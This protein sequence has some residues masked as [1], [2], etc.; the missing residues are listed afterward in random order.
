ML[1]LTIF[2]LVSLEV[3]NMPVII[4]NEYNSSNRTTLDFKNKV[5]KAAQEFLW[6]F[7]ANNEVR[8]VD[9]SGDGKYIIAGSHDGRIYVFNSN[10]NNTLWT[11]NTGSELR[12]VAMSYNGSYMVG[13]CANGYIYCF[14]ISSNQSLWNY[15][16]GQEI[17]TVDISATGEF[18]AAGGRSNIVYYFNNT[19]AD[20]K[21]PLWSFNTGNDI[22]A[23][24]L[25]ANGSYI[26]AGNGAGWLYFFNNSIT[27]PKAYE[28]ADRTPGM[29]TPWEI[30]ISDDGFYIA[31][32]DYAGTSN[33]VSFYNRTSDIPMWNYSIGAWL[34]GIAISGDGKYVVAGARTNRVYLFDGMNTVNPYLWEDFL[35][36][37]CW[38]VDISKNGEYIIAGT[39]D[40]GSNPQIYL[41][42]KA[43]N[44]PILQHAAPGGLGI[45]SVAAS[46][47]GEYFAAG[48]YSDKIITFYQNIPSAPPGPINLTHTASNPDDDGVFN[49]VWNESIG[50]ETYAIYNCTQFIT[51][52]NS[53][54]KEMTSGLINND[55]FEISG[56]DNGTY[57][58]VV[59]ARNID[60]NATSNCVE[61]NVQ[62]SPSTNGGPN[63]NGNGF[64]IIEFLTSPLGIVM[65]GSLIA[66]VSVIIIIIKKKGSD[67]LRNE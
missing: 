14:H 41:Y 40:S 28:W 17:L 62:I 18:I 63:G 61:I 48:T 58:Y 50:V 16:T 46:D 23:V 21:T 4:N 42:E 52:F 36:D 49:L 11:Y 53:S 6:N 19:A 43:S 1:S 20:P 66:T 59:V 25:S 31:C 65:I 3:I 9:V 64:N 32:G 10:N 34:E 12:S 13:G 39:Y 56:I 15:T 22:W 67:K 51:Q 57:Y 47:N 33:H 7:T 30:D 35:G 55:P 45:W 44:S 24:E 29:G 26:A 60:G 5:P 54:V 37:Y 2:L 8:S 27:I 38:T